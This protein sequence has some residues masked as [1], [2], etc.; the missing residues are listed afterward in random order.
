VA[1]PAEVVVSSPVLTIA[2]QLTILRMALVPFL[3]L[4]LVWGRYGLALVLFLVAGLTDLLD[5][6]I[7]RYG[8]QA[9][10]LG[11]TLDPVA[12]KLMLGAAFV[13]LTWGSGIE[14]VLP[15]WLTVLA[16]S[17]DVMMIVAVV[18]V[19]LTVERRVFVPSFLGKAC[20]LAQVVVAGLVI[21]SNYLGHAL[22]G[23]EEVYAVTL[24][25]IVGSATHYVYLASSRKTA[26]PGAPEQR[27]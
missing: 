25:L 24:A 16:L 13:V 19:N 23:L 1:G 27:P 7:A 17:R 9:T 22:P 20:T 12:D 11:A 8:R 14:V 26:K 5:G 21:V 6:L 18:V 10:A 3:V 4:A 15:V 2:N